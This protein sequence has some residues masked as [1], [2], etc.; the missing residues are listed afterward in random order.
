MDLM[1]STQQ[2][3]YAEIHIHIYIHEYTPETL[4]WHTQ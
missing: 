1:A 4:K 3:K 2:H